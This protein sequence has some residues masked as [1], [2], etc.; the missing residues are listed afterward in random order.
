M[1]AAAQSRT[2]RVFFVKSCNV[3]LLTLGESPHCLLRVGG[4]QPK[5]MCLS[6]NLPALHVF[7]SAERG[8]Y[9]VSSA[10]YMSLQPATRT[11]IR[12]SVFQRDKQG[13]ELAGGRPGSNFV[14]ECY[15]GPR[16]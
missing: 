12:Q 4:G 11:K 14:D 3:F 15:D 7:I 10:D 16:I 9:A 2:T 1:A 5:R 8:R 13:T 6:G